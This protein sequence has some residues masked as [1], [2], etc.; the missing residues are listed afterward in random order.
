M[1]VLLQLN[2]TAV[3]GYEVMQ[4]A[5]VNST[6]AVAMENVPDAFF[7]SFSDYTFSGGVL[8]T[9][10]SPTKRILDSSI[11]NNAKVKA[12]PWARNKS[13]K[14]KIFAAL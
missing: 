14:T 2:G 5:P 4:T 10:V 7:E 12:T 11:L 13:A 8:S 3:T 6:S 9:N 1:I